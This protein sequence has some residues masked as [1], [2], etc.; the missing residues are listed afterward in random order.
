METI[1]NVDVFL[2]VKS[3][4]RQILQLKI[5]TTLNR[6]CTA[7]NCVR[8]PVRGIN[9]KNKPEIKFK[10]AG[11]GNKNTQELLMVCKFETLHVFKWKKKKFVCFSEH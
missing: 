9:I 1:R 7:D 4:E 6:P 3:K 5:Q 11:L 2:S 8:S 10:F